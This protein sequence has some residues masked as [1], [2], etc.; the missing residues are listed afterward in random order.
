MSS[1]GFQTIYR[2]INT[3][4][5]HS[6]E[7]SFLPEPGFRDGPLLAY[8]TLDPV[9][10]FDVIAFSL[11]TE[12]EVTG[13][14]E[15]LR[16][17]GLRS[18]AR[19]RGAADPIV[20]VGGPLTFSNPLPAAPF[21]DVIVMGEAEPIL[22]PLLDLV[23]VAPTKEKLRESLA[24]L[25]GVFV[26]TVADAALPQLLKCSDDLLPAFSQLTTPNTELSDMH[27]VEV[28]RG[29]P[30]VCDFCVMRRTTNDGFRV[31]PK[32]R[33]LASVPETA[34][35]VGLVGAAVSDHPHL[36]EIVKSIVSSGR[37]IGVSS[38]RADCLSL[39]LISLLAQGGYKTLTVASDG[40]SERLRRALKKSIKERHL[41]EAAELAA[42]FK[43]R[44]LKIYMMLGVPGEDDED[45]DEL[46]ELTNELSVRSSIAL[47]V[48]PF[49]AKRNTPLEKERFAGVTVLNRRLKRLR[50]SLSPQVD[51]RS[52]SAR[53]AWVEYCLAQ[54]GP[55]MGH[56]A[57]AAQSAGSG[58]AA[59]KQA[60]KEHAPRFLDYL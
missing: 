58:F 51:L 19:E 4:T 38:L 17:A 60:V 52:T 36:L 35:R 23:A 33:V 40:A 49:V 8:E 47:A 5:E 24:E 3:E 30:R 16:L 39:D 45:L 9:G 21:V 50:K 28:G 34:H 27:L 54:G 57:R 15:C 14:V 7:R 46:I 18:L 42:R 56:A 20:L 37:G 31:V 55:E 32:E 43:L 13:I 25:P 44:V 11:A 22:K 26:P 48:S 10:D 1:L 6:A 59:W 12:L 2:L 41:W 29:C 53:W